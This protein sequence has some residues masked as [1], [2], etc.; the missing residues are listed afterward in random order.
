MAWNILGG[1]MGRGAAQGTLVPGASYYW[2]TTNG[3]PTKVNPGPMGATPMVPSTVTNPKAGST[4]NTSSG[5]PPD[6]DNGFGPV[7]DGPYINKPDEGFVY[8]PGVGTHGENYR[9]Y[10]DNNNLGLGT[11]FSSF[12][13]PERQATSPVMF[14]SLPTGAPVKGS[15][16]HPWQTLLFQPGM[17]GHAGLAAPKDEY[18]LDIFWMPQSEPY[19]I[20]EP[21]STAGKVNLNYQ[22]LPFTYIDRSTAIQSVLASEKVAAIPTSM[23]GTYKQSVGDF[24]G[25]LGLLGMTTLARSPLSMSEV[26]GTLRQFAQKFA[27][28]D[29]FHAPAEICDVYLVPQTLPTGESAWSSDAVG[30]EL[31]LWFR[32]RPGGR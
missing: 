12:D 2:G 17:T 14:G 24:Q 27:N 22:I 5:P 3:T 30:A 26:D 8:L 29:Y 4:N 32:F 16:P 23:A 13:S 18:L 6:F 9:P 11:N 15:T 25:S 1:M 21:F 7:P 31:L 28:L 19:A 10:F 20:S